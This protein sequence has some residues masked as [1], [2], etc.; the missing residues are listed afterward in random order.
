[1]KKIFALALAVIT[2]LMCSGV[3]ALEAEKPNGNFVSGDV[4]VV[5]EAE[6]SFTNHIYTPADFPEIEC[7]EVADLMPDTHKMVL[8]GKLILDEYRRMLILYLKEKT[9][10]AVL[11]AMIILEQ[12]DD[13]YN[14]SP[15]S[16]MQFPML[17]GDVN[18]DGEI[19][20]NDIIDICAYI[21]NP[22]S[23]PSISFRCAD[24]NRDGRINIDDVLLIR[25]II[26]S[27]ER[28]WT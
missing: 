19:N 6:F 24:V 15:N 28:L 26:F 7:D 20:I 25:D 16:Y 1:M 2:C 27:G 10:E 8:E 13:V 9:H 21:M 18:L 11:E 12:R 14:A 22:E 5:L 3:F 4:L 17:K 23:V